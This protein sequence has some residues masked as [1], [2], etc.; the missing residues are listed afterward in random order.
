M[1]RRHIYIP[2]NQVKPN[3]PTDHLTWIGKYIVE[4]KPDVVINAGDFGDMP[5]LSV[6]DKGKKL[7]EGVRVIDDINACKTAWDVLNKPIEK[8]NAKKRKN[9]EKQYKPRKIITL[10]NHEDRINRHVNENPEL[11]GFLSVDNLELGRYGWEVHDF[12][13]I[14][15]VDGVH[16]SHFFA[17]P[18]NGRPYGGMLSTRLKNI[19]FSF[20][21]GH[22]QT[23]DT[24]SRYLANGTRQRGLVCGCC[25]LYDDN[26]RK[27]ANTAWHGIFQ[28]NEVQDGDYD[29][30][31]ISLDYLCRRYEGVTLKKF[32]ME[33]Y[34]I[35]LDRHGGAVS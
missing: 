7:G 27:Q 16:Y 28:L 2:D 17:S 34:G 35:V 24:T 5:S 6:Y 13:D 11:F 25:Y 33:K 1:V 21:M 9:K 23:R 10:G 30:L 18:M 22:Q 31:E 29:L 26:Y 20:V 32:M 12:L 14:V 8:F 19:G 3:T 4:Q 15:A